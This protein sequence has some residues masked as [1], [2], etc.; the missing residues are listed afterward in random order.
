MYGGRKLGVSAALKQQSV[1][2]TNRIISGKKLP[3]SRPKAR[4]NNLVIPPPL[5][6]FHLPLPRS[7]SSLIHA[8]WFVV[9]RKLNPSTLTLHMPQLQPARDINSTGEKQRWHIH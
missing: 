7:I 8:P 5:C 4:K 9:P 3:I 2:T 6:S 1:S